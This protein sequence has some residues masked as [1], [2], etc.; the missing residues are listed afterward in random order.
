MSHSTQYRSF[1][2]DIFTG[3]FT[4]IFPPPLKLRPYGGIEM[5]VLLLLLCDPTN[6][7]KALKEDGQSSDQASIP[8]GPA[9]RVTIIQHACSE[10]QENTKT[11]M[12]LSTVK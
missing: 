5:C 6:S 10:I 8:P 9:H 4:D 11:H 12:H 1:G 3:I 7:V 2:D